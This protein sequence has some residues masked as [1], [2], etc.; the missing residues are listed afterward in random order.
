M[1]VNQKT[2]IVFSQYD[3]FG[4]H[5]GHNVTRRI[6]AKVDSDMARLHEIN[7]NI[8]KRGLVLRS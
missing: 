6:L 5:T 3:S 4:L 8:P 7:Q 2:L 1:T